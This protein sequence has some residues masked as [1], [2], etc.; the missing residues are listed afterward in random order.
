MTT[1]S[2][3]GNSTAPLPGPPQRDEA[4]S[5]SRTPARLTPV[6]VLIGLVLLPFLV[7]SWIKHDVDE[8]AA[9]A[10][11]VMAWIVLSLSATAIVYFVFR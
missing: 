2:V 10:V 7:W 1:S 8:D 3:L 5:R 11:S 6:S 4:P 9:A